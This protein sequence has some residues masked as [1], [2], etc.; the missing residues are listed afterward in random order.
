MMRMLL[1]LAESPAMPEGH[2]VHRQARRLGRYFTGDK[3]KISSPQ[4]RF[5]SGADLLD[6]T[7][8]LGT[9]AFGKHLLVAFA[10]D[11]T[12]HVH[13]GLYGKWTMGKAPEPAA[14]G[15][16]RVR[17]VGQ[18]YYADLRGPT[19]CEVLDPD[20]RAA[21]IA[22]IG[23][24]PI[25]KDADPERAWRRITASRQT[26]AA[27]LMD[28]TV[29]A[30]VGNIYRAEALFRAGIDPYR[31]GR[32]VGRA[33]FDVMWDD[34]VLLMRDGVRTGRIDTVRE[35]HSPD[36]LGRAKR[37]DRHGG[38]V[39]VYRRA[40]QD[41]HVCGDEVLGTELNGRNLFWCPTCQAR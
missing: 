2:V 25:R 16:I 17:L 13:L 3:P 14:R 12:L 21:L 37:R 33:E 41:C 26:I 10:E 24:D 8:V 29:F 1:I 9:D 34:L 28:Q 39:Y 4:G 22:R 23:P 15:L 20:Q 38:E 11:R 7:S 19:A 31:L 40:G 35:E 27:L 32:E 5:T 30:G 36:A 18:K 6:E